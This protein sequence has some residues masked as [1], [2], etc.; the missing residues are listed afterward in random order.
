MQQLNQAL[1]VAYA[2]FQRGDLDTAR[3]KLK[4]HK[5][6]KAVHLLALVEKAAGDLDAARA[7]LATAAKSDPSDP[8]IANNQGVLARKMEDMP[9]AEK[10]FRRALSI[11]PDFQQAS[12]GLGRLLIDS[13]RWEDAAAVYEPLLA[14]SPQDVT[15]RFGYAT[16][17]LELGAAETAEAIFDALIGAGNDVP[18]I[19]FMR[20]RARLQLRRIDDALVDLRESYAAGPSNICLRLY[21][22]AMWMTGDHD[23]FEKLLASAAEQPELWATPERAQKAV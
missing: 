9:G 6:P 13:K 7:L 19:R 1:Q 3:K 18:E 12:T 4:R 16:V 8:E 23:G 2:A 5:H 21:A 20:A 11:R 10:A 22:G 17:Q 15:V 14:A